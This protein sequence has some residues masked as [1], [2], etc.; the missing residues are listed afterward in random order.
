MKLSIRSFLLIYLLLTVAITTAISA[1]CNY[2][3]A[4]KN[5]Q[6]HLDKIMEVSANSYNSLATAKITK[7]NKKLANF[8]V[9]IWSKNKLVL[10]SLNFP[11]FNLPNKKGFSNIII[12]KQKWRVFVSY[13]SNSQDKIIIYEKYI[14][15]LKLIKKIAIENLYIMLMMFPIV[16]LLIWIII[17][18]GLKS[19][20]VMAK[21]LANRAPNH[22]E[23]VKLK[24]LPK[25]ITP[26]VNELN[27]L[28]YRLKEAFERETRF[29]T[30]AAHELRTPLAALKAQAQV[31]LHTNAIEEK[32]IALQKVIASVNRNTHIVQQLLTMSKLIP[33]EYVNELDDINLTQITREILALL[34]PLALNNNIELEFINQN[35]IGV[36][37]GNPTAIS[38]LIRNIVENAIKYSYP[39]SQIS[40]NVLQIQDKIILEVKDTGPGIPEEL[41]SRVFERFFRSLGN[42]T[43]GSGLGLAI[44]Q[45]I[46]NLHNAKITLESQPVG[47]GLI[48]KVFFNAK[49]R[50]MNDHKKKRNKYKR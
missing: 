1:I 23:P 32:N 31:A 16:G 14:S 5:I 15:R 8:G 39:N 27:N 49:T 34:A 26:V 40:V 25:E 29:A 17:G 24:N 45:Q 12:N 38:I 36:F 18:K 46:I 6:Q 11:I 2:Y 21:E 20:D 4:Q 35:P 37:L 43:T 9:Q 47:T 3:L 50:I 13:D 28:L 41:Q 22:L 19:L 7:N 30:D 48:V 10:D 33:D 42:R 44:V